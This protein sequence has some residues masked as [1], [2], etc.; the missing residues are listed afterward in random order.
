[1]HKLVTVWKAQLDTATIL[2]INCERMREILA[3]STCNFYAST[4]K[5]L[6]KG[7]KFWEKSLIM[8]EIIN[9]N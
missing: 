6:Q 8:K 7:Q 3:L 1:M 2:Q 4:W 9:P 5:G